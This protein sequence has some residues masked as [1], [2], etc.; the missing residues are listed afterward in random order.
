MTTAALRRLVPTPAKRAHERAGRAVHLRRVN[1]LNRRVTAE[2][3]LEVRRGPFAGL[4][5]PE[6][7]VA[8]HGDLVAK[9]VGSYE[10]ELAPVLASWVGRVGTLVDVGAAEGFYAVGMAVA[11]PGTRVV[12]FEADPAAREQ[13]R[14]L[15]EHNGVAG[16]VELRGE[17]TAAE[18]AALDGDGVAVLCDCEGCEVELLDP[19]VVPALRRRTLLVELHDFA[20]AGATETI[21][22][23][24]A[25]THDVELIEGR[26]RDGVRPPELAGLPDRDRLRLLG[27][28]RPGPMRWAWLRPREQAAP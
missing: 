26:G 2:H 14:L 22:A 5:Y 19:A 6:A 16:R 27:E 17:A 18:L 20:V 24:F 7:L 11:S 8:D 15:A 13:C 28:R 12:A 1:A 23:R 3:G 4:R 25:P 21:R 10:L 9:L